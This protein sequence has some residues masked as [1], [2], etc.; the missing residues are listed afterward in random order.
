MHSTQHGSRSQLLF[1]AAVRLH[2]AG[3]VEGALAA[4]RAVLADF[5]DLAAAH[6]NAGSLLAQSG[7]FDEARAYF[8]QAVDL[9]PEYA[10]AR[11]NL[12][13]A[14]SQSARATDA[15]VELQ[16]AVDAEPQ[17]APWWGDLGNALLSEQRYAEALAAFD[18]ALQ[19]APHDVP[20][21]ANRAIALRGLR[22]HD[23][24]AAACEAALAINPRYLDALSN[25]GVIY[26]E[27]RRFDDARRAFQRA[28]TVAPGFPTA[29]VNL[30]VLEMELDQ[31]EAAEEVANA[32]IRDHPEFAEAWNVLG[33]CALE[34]GDFDRAEALHLQTLALEPENRNAQWNL[35][36]IW[37]LRGDFARGLPQYEARLRLVS[38]LFDRK[39][40]KE[41]AWDG[42]PLDGRTLLV[43]A[44]QGI[45]DTVQYAR[46]AKLLK[47]QGAGRILLECQPAI[48][49][50]VASAAGIDVVIPQGQPI[51]AFDVHCYLMSLPLLCGTT[52]ETIPAEARYLA[53]PP[54][55]AATSVTAAPGERR[56]GVVWAGNPI[57]QRDRIRSIPLAQLAPLFTTPRTRF[58]SLQKGPAAAELSSVE[59]AA[60]VVNL[61]PVLETFADTAAVIEALDLV[62]TVDTSV[63]HLAAALGKPTWILVP[64]V[65]DF[66]W[67]LDRDDSPWYPTVR[68]LRQRSRRDWGEVIARACA[69]LEAWTPAVGTL[70]DAAPPVRASIVSMPT[71]PR[72]LRYVELDWQV[73]L[74]SGWG[75]YGMH[76]ALQLARLGRAAPVL[77]EPPV[78]SGI[79]AETERALVAMPR[80]A[81]ADSAHHTAR[82]TALGNGLVGAERPAAPRGARRVGIVFFEDTA[83]D[84][85]MIERSR[86]YD[87]IVAGSTFNAELLKAFGI[88]PVVTVLQGVDP[89][90]FHAAPRA[91][92]FGQRPVVFSG[93]KLEFR[94]GQDIV[95]AAFRELLATHPDALLVTAWHNHWPATMVGIDAMGHVHGLPEV[96]DGVM[97]TTAWLAAN[98]I[99]ERNVLDLGLQTQAAV[100][101]VVREC[102]VAVFP[103]RCE[104]GTN[105][106]AM[107]AMAAG[108]PVIL[109]ANSGH[110]N[111]IGANTCFVLERQDEVTVRSP[112]YRSMWGWGESHPGE[113]CAQM[114]HVIAHPEKARDVAAN[115]AGLLA[116][117]PWS[118]Q[119]ELLL[120]QLEALP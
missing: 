119:A 41:P 16:R 17:R 57:H 58:F 54:R 49:E 77:V 90:V 72:A 56:V 29:M 15:I 6:N 110:L 116:E 102:T 5:P 23:E 1:D 11:H 85:A 73:G 35:A 98:G 80:A 114:E 76:L 111:L 101:A 14:L 103:N 118:R 93:G 100:A 2:L 81:P 3:N 25:L 62:I 26:K 27:Q 84:A 46:Y 86:A 82:L 87:L 66:R 40:F 34:R 96:R 12:G 51:P 94:K 120:D 22:R 113:L 105:L 106:V 4:Y 48:A 31:H 55:T 20:T 91:G 60:A 83:I 9:Q 70:E 115:G 53:A 47:T 112:L 18:R 44:E 37:L 88:G 99:P 64:L 28:L 50:V 79:S 33:N 38:V 108:I 8:A 45:G 95:V 68:L 75:T 74:G 30:A 52:P 21:T 59:A 67:M 13:L 65:P 19:R 24:A 69:L 89:T 63:A 78:R 92:R 42:S 7:R 61:D 117:L 97:H 43:H 39:Q 107:E 10:E 109:S 104:G 71:A 36:V 32:I